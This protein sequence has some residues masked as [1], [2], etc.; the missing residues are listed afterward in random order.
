MVFATAG[1]TIPVCANK[2][3]FAV[4]VVYSVQASK[5]QLRRKVKVNWTAPQGITHSFKHRL[6]DLLASP[7]LGFNVRAE[8]RT[9][10]QGLLTGT[11]QVAVTAKG[12]T[13]I[14][15]TLTLSAAPAC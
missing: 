13:L 12:K 1:S 15:S 8:N 6:R 10:Q 14:A 9:A 2:P 7:P 4:A 11:Y 5:K 3:V